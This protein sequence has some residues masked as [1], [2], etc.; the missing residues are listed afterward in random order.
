MGWRGQ[1]G[2]WNDGLPGECG[3]RARAGNASPHRGRCIG[4]EW[5][6]GLKPVEMLVGCGGGCSREIQ[7]DDG[8]CP[9]TYIRRHSGEDHLFCPLFYP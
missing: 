4:G 8:V 1:A 3:H 7:V 2:G 6:F 5:S 9:R